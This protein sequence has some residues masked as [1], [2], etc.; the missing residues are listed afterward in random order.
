MNALQK[1]ASYWIL[2]IEFALRRA[3]F[4]TGRKR[5]SRHD[6]SNAY[7]LNT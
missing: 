3:R 4:L 7:G 6:L 2:T 5:E 1:T